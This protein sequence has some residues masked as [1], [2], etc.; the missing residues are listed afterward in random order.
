MIKI[1]VII[2][3]YNGE[4]YLEH[5]L[6]TILSQKME[7]FEVLLID[8]GSKDGSAAL[9]DKIASE[10]SKVRVLH[11]ENQGICGARNTGIEAAR[12]EYLAF[13]DQDDECLPGWLE[14]NYQT[15]VEYDADL[16]KSGRIAETVDENGKLL[17]RDIRELEKKFYDREQLIGEY[18]VL[19]DRN[20]FS[21]VWDGLFRREI[22]MK[23]NIRFRTEFR[24]GEE[25]TAFCLE[26]LQY[27]QRFATNTGIY[28]R[29]FERYATSTSSV[30]NIESLNGLVR[31]GVIE[32]QVKK[33]MGLEQWTADAVLSSAKNHL[34]PVLVQLFHRNCSWPLKRRRDFIS[35][36]HSSEA[37]RYKIDRDVLREIWKRDKKKAFI[38]DQFM[39]RHDSMLLLTAKF[40]RSILTRKL[41]KT[42][43]QTEQ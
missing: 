12:G 31:S 2:P 19:R 30:F 18:F 40:Y 33:Q 27:V 34:I 15:A 7:E 43:K 5:T 35:S 38:V 9:C 36:L 17:K 23:Y 16:V 25:D 11:Q 20:V 10:N 21:P 14:D 42:V 6:G 29:H 22:V 24:Q 41:K 37:F 26:F 3:V 8:D 32:E 28:F 39:R 1:S 4:K 13:A